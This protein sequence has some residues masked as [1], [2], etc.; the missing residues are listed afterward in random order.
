MKSKLTIF[1]FILVF[2]I[3]IFGIIYKNTIK[4]NR[5]DITFLDIGQGTS[6]FVE[7]PSG[8]QILIDAGPNG[9]SSR[10]LS[11]KMNF[12]DK[13]IDLLIASHPDAD[14]I[15]GFPEIVKNYSFDYFLKNNN[16]SST[17]YFKELERRLENKIVSDL[18]TG[19]KIYVD[20]DVYILVLFPDIDTTDFETNTSSVIFKLVYERGDTDDDNSF[21][22]LF[23]GDSP[24][25]IERY[26]SDLFPE[27][28]KSDILVVGHH[29]SKTST[30]EDFLKL[31]DPDY[32]VITV[33][34]ENRYGHPHADVLDR[35]EK[36][37]GEMLRTDTMGD[38][39]FLV[40][41]RKVFV[42]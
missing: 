32:S 17:S 31:V 8:K 21:S 42:K 26:V 20:D 1:I 9:E 30:D 7:T 6:I 14:H 15:G 13:H 38:I 11:K 18:R 39:R 23:T 22:M 28:L 33:G 12:W 2:L 16:V 5:L 40:D 4:F 27:L 36:W 10:K 41:D 25:K 3:P 29:G 35:L 19:D 24:K 37:G 34:R